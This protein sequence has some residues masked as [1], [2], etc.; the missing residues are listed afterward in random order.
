MLYSR[1]EAKKIDK[2]SYE[3]GR[4]DALE[5]LRELGFDTRIAKGNLDLLNT[6]VVDDFKRQIPGLKLKP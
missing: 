6:M 5:L 4:T 3:K 2:S 1:F